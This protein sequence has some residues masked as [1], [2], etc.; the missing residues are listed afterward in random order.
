MRFFLPG[1]TQFYIAEALR[2]IP[3]ACEA[4][5]TFKAKVIHDNVT[6]DFG[7]DVEIPVQG[8]SVH[9]SN[10]CPD[11]GEFHFVRLSIR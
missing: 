9:Y 4:L 5:M 7:D 6:L 3:T 8:D 2:Q 11:Y 1:N 10:R